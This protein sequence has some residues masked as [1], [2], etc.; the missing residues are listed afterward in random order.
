MAEGPQQKQAA[1]PEEKERS[2]WDQIK[3]MRP[4]KQI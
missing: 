4:V 3:G 1:K 2:K